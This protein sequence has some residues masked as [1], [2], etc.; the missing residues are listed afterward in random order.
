MSYIHVCYTW[1]SSIANTWFGPRFWTEMSRLRRS[2]LE[3]HWHGDQTRKNS[4][5]KQAR[6]SVRRSIAG[7][8]DDRCY[9]QPPTDIA[10]KV[11]FLM[12]T[13]LR[14]SR[15]R[16]LFIVPLWQVYGAWNR[17]A[18]NTVVT[19]LERPHW[20]ACLCVVYI[21]SWRSARGT[22]VIGQHVFKYLFSRSKVNRTL[23]YVTWKTRPTR[24]VADYELPR[25]N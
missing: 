13:A 21:R 9:R 15:Y 4:H 17:Y 18:V 22:Q 3:T 5:L 6:S 8:F 12:R 24:R 2:L 1:T 7:E 16:V 11:A 19:G 25:T 10:F 20:H 14:K 23:N